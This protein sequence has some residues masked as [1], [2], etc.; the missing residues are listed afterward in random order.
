MNTKVLPCPFCGEDAEADRQQSFRALSDGKIHSNVAIYCP[1]CPVNMSLSRADLPEYTDDELY[2]VLVEKWNARVA[3]LGWQSIET[4]PKDGTEVILAVKMRAGIRHGILVGHY[5]E[6][7]FCIEDHPAIDAGW[8]F[9]NGSMF[10]LAS[11]PTHWKPLP[12]L[13]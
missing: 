3:Q 5:M 13:P 7:G 10:D 4:A 1:K 11:K 2:D 12:P 6:G 9:W 8:Y